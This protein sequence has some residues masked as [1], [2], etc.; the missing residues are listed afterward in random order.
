[1]LALIDG[2]LVVYRAAAGAETE[3]FDVAVEYINKCLQHI[4]EATSC[5]EYRAYLSSPNN[6]RKSIYAEYKANRT[7]PKPNWLKEAQEYAV[8]HLEFIWADATLEADDMLGINQ[9]DS[10]IIC[11]LDKDLL[12]VPGRHFQWA[13]AG[14]PVDKRWEK[15]DTTYIISERQGWYNFYYQCLVGDPSDN[16]KGVAGVGKVGATKLLHDTNTEKE[17]FDIVREQYNNDE[18][19]IMNASCLYVLRHKKD[20]FKDVFERNK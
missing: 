19:F 3:N 6:F 5:S 20:S 18:E 10:T 12:Q 17:M 2:D 11:S 16:V 14:G 9:T 4:L 13:I 15:P 7:Q 1:M 8:K